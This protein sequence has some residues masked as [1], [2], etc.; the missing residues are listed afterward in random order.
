MKKFNLIALIFSICL[1]MVS[2]STA[3]AQ[4]EMPS[5]NEPKQNQNKPNRP[6]LLAELDLT[7]DQIQ[8]IRRINSDKR[9]LMR[10]AQQKV[11]EANRNLD[12]AIY[13]DSSDETEIQARLKDV[14]LAQ[15]E[16]SKLRAMTEYAVRKVLTPAQ[17]SKFRELRLR[18]IENLENRVEQRR[19]RPLKNQNQRLNNRQRDF[20]P[21]N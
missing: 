12:Q 17:L 11:R 18:F 5:D 1:L 13:S 3:R 21:I 14:Q 15:A 7:I 6:N 8:Q 4:S 10:E 20:R 2:F 16:I 9:P 19:N